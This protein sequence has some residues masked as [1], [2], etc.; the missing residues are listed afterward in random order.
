[1]LKY[2]GKNLSRKKAFQNFS[3]LKNKFVVDILMAA[4]M[5]LLKCKSCKMVKAVY[6]YIYI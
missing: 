4:N 2:H 3:M 6:I 1:M 5:C